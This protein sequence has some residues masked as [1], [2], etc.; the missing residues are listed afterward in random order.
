MKRSTS[1]LA[2]AALLTACAESPVAPPAND[3]APAFSATTITDNFV[4][5]FAADVFIPCALGG[6]GE[7]ASLSGNLH[8]LTHI[9]FNGAGGI[10]LKQHFQPQNLG[11]TGLTSGHNYRG[12]GVTQETLNIAAA[13]LPVTSTFVNNFR[14]IGQGPGNNFHVHQLIHVTVDANGVV[15]AVVA[16][17]SVTCS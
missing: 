6:A 17:S 12:V 9:T 1:I 15:R 3:L 8:V 11:G 2:A 5:P 10:T 7:W 13:G 14:M 16:N 4:V